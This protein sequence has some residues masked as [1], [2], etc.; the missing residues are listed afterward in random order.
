MTGGR[1]LDTDSAQIITGTPALS[2]NKFTVVSAYVEYVNASLYGYIDSSLNLSSS[3]FQT[4][5]Y[6][7]NTCYG[8]RSSVKRQHLG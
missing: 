1:R 8:R 6:S 3:L 4:K 5:G 2:Q 7:D